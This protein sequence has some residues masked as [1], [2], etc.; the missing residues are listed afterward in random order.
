M[1]P[2]AGQ[3]IGEA[4]SEVRFFKVQGSRFKVQG[5]RF[6]AKDMCKAYIA[7]D[8]DGGGVHGYSTLTF[9]L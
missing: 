5:S 9:T 3:E 4:P 6:K 1:A 8:G 2:E 7:D